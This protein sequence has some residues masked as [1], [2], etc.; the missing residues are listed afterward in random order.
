LGDVD[1]LPASYSLKVTPSHLDQVTATLACGGCKRDDAGKVRACVLDCDFNQL[2][3]PRP[4]T[5]T[6]THDLSSS[7]DRIGQQVT[8][9]RPLLNRLQRGAGIH[10]RP[11]PVSQAVKERLHLGATQHVDI[12]RA[13]DVGVSG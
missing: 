7:G 9:Q 11:W 10:L 5:V 13:K 4:V 2:L 6:T 3:T 1:A 8:H 12:D